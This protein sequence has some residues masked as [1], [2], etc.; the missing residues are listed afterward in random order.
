MRA[1]P[2][3]NLTRAVVA[4]LGVAVLASACRPDEPPPAPPEEPDEGAQI[5]APPEPMVWERYQMAW[6]ADTG[7]VNRAVAVAP[8]GWVVSLN[9][10]QIRVHAPDTG[11]VLE[12]ADQCG[13]PADGLFF[14]E[15]Q[16]ALVVCARELREVRFP[17]LEWRR[18]TEL[19]FDAGHVDAAGGLLAVSD[20]RNRVVVF[21]TNAWT[22]IDES[23]IGRA[24]V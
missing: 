23:K 9:Q 5:E 1:G 12:A 18:I 24:H 13:G 4:S 10:A 16:K 11:K 8:G 19:P 6:L 21:E 2:M 7:A 22:R 20:G 3:S 17:G 15:P 14:T